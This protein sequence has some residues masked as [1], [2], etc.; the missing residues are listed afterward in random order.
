[1]KNFEFDEVFDSVEEAFAKY[2]NAKLIHAQMGNCM[3]CGE[4]QDLRA[5]VCFDCCDKV[6]GEPI[7]GGHRLWETENPKNTWYVGDV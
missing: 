6:S 1:M 3:V 2:P 4:R 7:K 5:G